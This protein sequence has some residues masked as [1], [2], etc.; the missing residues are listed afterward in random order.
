MLYFNYSTSL[1]IVKAANLIGD[2]YVRGM[3]MT[4]APSTVR[5]ELLRHCIEPLHALRELNAQCEQDPSFN[6]LFDPESNA[7]A[8]DVYERSLR[9]L[10]E[11]NHGNITRDAR[12]GMGPCPGCGCVQLEQMP[13]EWAD[14]KFWCGPCITYF[15]DAHSKLCSGFLTHAI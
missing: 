1:I 2:L 3:E 6:E 9:E 8:I 11:L 14:G 13:S 15:S 5:G 4:L 10:A 7:R 12:D